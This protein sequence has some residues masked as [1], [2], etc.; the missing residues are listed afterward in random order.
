M[1]HIKDG[2]AAFPATQPHHML[3]TTTL[4]MSLRDYFAA[5]VISSLFVMSPSEIN[6][7]A[8]GYWNSD[9]IAYS[10]EFAYML[11]DA[12]LKARES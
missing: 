2:G 3:D 7:V 11:A 6:V 10:A 8:P 9:R 5:K 12:M 4:G 1:S